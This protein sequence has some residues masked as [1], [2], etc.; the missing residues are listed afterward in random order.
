LPAPLADDAL[1][2][3]PPRPAAVPPDRAL[4]DR[5]AADPVPAALPRPLAPPERVPPAVPDARRP[6][7]LPRPGGGIGRMTSGDSSL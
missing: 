2:D 3:R 7:P 1:P 6:P 5:P 4:A